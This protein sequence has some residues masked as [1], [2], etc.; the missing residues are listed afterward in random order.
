[1]LSLGLLAFGR[2]DAATNNVAIAIDAATLK[3][4]PMSRRA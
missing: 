4:R 2:S 3:T 1:L